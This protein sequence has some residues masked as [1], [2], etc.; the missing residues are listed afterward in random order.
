VFLQHEIVLLVLP[1]SEIALKVFLHYLHAL[2]V[3]LQ[4]GLALPAASSPK[5]PHYSA[6]SLIPLSPEKQISGDEE[7]YNRIMAKRVTGLIL[8]KGGMLY[9][10]NG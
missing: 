3:I 1:H 4:Q 10:P 5:R 6:I 8:I 9:E 2:P 7:W